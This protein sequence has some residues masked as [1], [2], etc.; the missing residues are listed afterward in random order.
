MLLGDLQG[1]VDAFLDRNRRHHDD[2]LGKAVAFIQFKDAA[3]VHVG[4]ARAGFHFDG[5]VA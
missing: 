5:K 4:F 2:E 1:L 3:Q